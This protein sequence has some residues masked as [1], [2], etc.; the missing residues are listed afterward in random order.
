[1][2]KTRKD[3]DDAWKPLHDKLTRLYYVEKKIS[4]ELFEKAHAVLWLLHEKESIENGV[5]PDYEVD[6][7]TRQKRSRQIV[8]LLS[9]LQTHDVVSLIEQLRKL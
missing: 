3:V 7:I 2:S 1:M 9:I 4:R 6:E 5:L 8:E